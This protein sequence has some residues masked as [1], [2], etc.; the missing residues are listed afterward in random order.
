MTTDHTGGTGDGE[1]RQIL[2]TRIRLADKLR[3]LELAGK[4]LKVFANRMEH[5]ASQGLA[6]ALRAALERAN[7]RAAPASGSV[8]ATVIEHKQLGP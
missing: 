2:R 5:D 7:A 3:A 6:E 4:H 1:R 8:D